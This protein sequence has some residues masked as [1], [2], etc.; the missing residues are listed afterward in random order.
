MS[1]LVERLEDRLDPDCHE[2]ADLSRNLRE[3]L[4]W[5]NSRINDLRDL[6][7]AARAGRQST[8]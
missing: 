1:D 2:A 4:D 6:L 7:A 3:D 5:A 8:P